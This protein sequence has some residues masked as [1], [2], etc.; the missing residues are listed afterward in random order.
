MCSSD[1][2]EPDLGLTRLETVRVSRAAADQRRGRAGRTEPGVC[3]RL[4]EEAATGAL[5]AF[6]RPEIL[7]ADLSG[8]VLD[9][10]AWGARDP[11]SLRWL[12]PPPAPAVNE[13]R[14]LLRGLGA[15]DADGAIT[16]M[17]R[18]IR[19]LPL[20]P[21]LARMVIE[22]ARGGE[23]D[24]A[25]MIAV[26]LVERGLGGNA[27]D[28]ADRV[29]HLRRERGRRGEDARRMAAEIGRAHV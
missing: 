26:V 6:A 8:L 18:A 29:E 16:D 25:A 14:A 10:A 13:A 24:L 28:I 4:W 22:A 1:L 11:A 2:Y 7:D 23:E 17:G 27:I 15:L 19:A 3:Y 12:D 9:L 5:D 21:R 20:P